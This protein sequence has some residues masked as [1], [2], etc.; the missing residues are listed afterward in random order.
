M[1]MRFAEPMAM[2]ISYT[3]VVELIASALQRI[4]QFMAIAPLPVAEQSEMPERYD[5]RFDNVSY[6]YEEG[7]GHALNHVSLTFPAA[8]MSAL[9]GASGAGKTTVTKLLMRY[10]DPQQGQISIGGVDI[11]RLT[12]E[13]LNSLISVVF[14]DVWLFDDT[15]LANIRIARPQATRQEVEEAARAAQCLEFISRL[16]QGWL[17]PMG[18]MGGQLSGGERQRISI[19]RALLKNAPVVILDEPTAALDIESELAVQKAIDNLVYNRTV[20]IIAHRLSTIAGAGNILVME[21]GQVVEQGTHAQLPHIMD[22]IRR[23]GRRK[24]PRACGATTGFP[25]LES[26][27]MSDVQSNVKPLTLTTGRVIFAIAGVYVTQSLVSALSMQSL[28]A[29]VRAAGGSLALAGATTLFMLPWA[30]KF[31]WAPWIERWRLPPGSQE[32]R[33]RMLILRGQVALAAILTIAAAIGWFGREG[34]F[35]DT[36][37]V[38]LFVLFMVAGT[39]ASTIDIASDGFCVDQLTRTGYGWG[40]SVQVGGSYLGMMCGGG[41]S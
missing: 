14:Q 28:P 31:I 3:S 33:S 5:I 23:C 39:V 15:L 21:E 17:T 10:A 8:S 13:Q 35:P 32:R 18:E 9:V 24:W 20:I 6:R 40:N 38:A 30:L 22:V 37:I 19:A 12:P 11:R 7:D 41:C 27:G 2:F 25:R 16:P 1:I 29:L 26:G 36:Q 4:E 34:G